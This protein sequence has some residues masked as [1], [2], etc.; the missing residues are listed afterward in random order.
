M[1]EWLEGETYGEFQER[2]RIAVAQAPEA[3]PRER[4][5]S[6]DDE[7]VPAMWVDQA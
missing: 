3:P 5:P 6:D 1:I 2:V 7:E 4:E